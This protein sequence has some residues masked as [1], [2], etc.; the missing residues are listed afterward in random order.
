[1]LNMADV[2][3]L[4]LQL[5]HLVP[6]ES[7]VLTI[8]VELVDGIVEELVAHGPVFQNLVLGVRIGNKGQRAVGIGRTGDP[9]R[10]LNVGLVSCP[11]TE[12]GVVPVKVKMC[13]E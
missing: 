13:E 3:E 2:D 7:A 11:G 1:M 8:Q 5:R 9:I 10:V 12:L 4:M 6:T